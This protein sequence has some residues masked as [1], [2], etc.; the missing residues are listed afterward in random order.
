MELV[1]VEEQGDFAAAHA[2]VGEDLRFVRGN[3]ALNCLDLDGDF[4][5][6]ERVGTV[7]RF[8]SIAAVDD[9]DWRLSPERRSGRLLSLEGNAGFVDQFQHPWAK[10]PVHGDRE[11][12]NLLGEG[13][14]DQGRRSWSTGH[15]TAFGADFVS[16]CQSFSAPYARHKYFIPPPTAKYD[17]NAAT[18][19][20][21]LADDMKVCKMPERVALVAGAGL[22][23][24]RVMVLALP[25]GGHR[26]FMTSKDKATRR[27]T[28]RASNAGERA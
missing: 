11:A 4:V 25:G 22:G 19:V 9:W 6:E 23:R 5:V 28:Q 3:G 10:S 16:A 7:A 14:A 8:R 21:P 15:A 24:G 26:E 20:D 17:P 2:W 18:L 12:D 27:A 13:C 1:A